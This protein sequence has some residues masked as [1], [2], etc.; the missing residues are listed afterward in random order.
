M[1]RGVENV[2]AGWKPY[3]IVMTPRSNRKQ[4]SRYAIERMGC[5]WWWDL[6]E[7]DMISKRR[8][9]EVESKLNAAVTFDPSRGQAE[10]APPTL[11]R[12]AGSPIH[13]SH[14]QSTT[15]LRLKINL[16]FALDGYFYDDGHLC[17]ILFFPLNEAN[18]LCTSASI[19]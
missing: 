6:L 1:P 17:M 16:A 11:S 12:V 15:N 8:F 9:A 3:D 5:V 18:T 13:S 10:S 14:I 4:Y 2:E 7:V 19:A